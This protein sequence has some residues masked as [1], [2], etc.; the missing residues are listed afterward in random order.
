[1][2]LGIVLIGAAHGLI[3]LPVLLSYVGPYRPQAPGPKKQVF[4]N[5]K[6]LDIAQMKMNTILKKLPDLKGKKE[7][8]PSRG[9]GFMEWMNGIM[10]DGSWKLVTIVF[11]RAQTTF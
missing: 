11:F 10:S 7:K 6:I 1:M 5:G 9:W 2:Y 8:Y 4:Y 3:F